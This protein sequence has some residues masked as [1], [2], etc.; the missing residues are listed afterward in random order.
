M[1]SATIGGTVAGAGNTIAFNNGPGVRIRNGATGILVEGNAIHS[2]AGLGID[3]M[4]GTENGFAVTANDALDA[5]GGA[6]RLQNYPLLYGANVVG[7]NLTVYGEINSTASRL[8]RIEFFASPAADASGYGEGA[9]YLGFMNVTT[10]AAG[11][12]Q[13]STTLVGAAVAAGEVITATATDTTT[14]DTS[15][16]SAS[17]VANNRTLSGTVYN[18]LN[19]NANVADDGGAV[20]ANATVR[21]YM[22]DGDGVMDAGDVSLGATTTNGAGLYSFSNLG[23]ATYWV[24]VDSKTL[25]APAYNGVF[26]INDVWADQTYGDDSTTGALDL[27]ARYGGR[28]AAVSDN[29]AALTTAEHV[30]R[31]TIAGAN[32]TGVDSGFSFSAIVNTRGDTTDDDAANARLQQGSLRQF[33]LNSNAIAGVQTSNFSIGGGGAQTITLTASLANLTDAAVLNATTQEGFAGSPLIE[34]RGGGVAVN[35]F[36]V[37]T[38][39][40]GSTIRGFVIS[41]FTADA[42]ELIGDNNLVGGNWIGTDATGNAAAALR[43]AEAGVRIRAGADNNTVG[44][45]TAADRNVLSGNG[46]GGDPSDN[47]LTLLGGNNTIQGNYI[48]VGADGTTVIGNTDEGMDVGTGATNNLIGGLVAGAGNIIAGSVGNLGIAVQNTA[49]GT[50]I[51]GNTIYGNDG[52]IRIQNTSTGTT[53]SRNSIYGNA[54]LGINLAGGVE[55]NDVTANDVGD[56]DTGPNGLQN[57]PVLASAVTNGATQITIIGSLNSTASRTFRIEFFS[58]PAADA[59]SGHGEG[60]TYLGFVDVTT[61]GSGNASFNTTLAANVPVGASITATA[62]DLT[63]NETSEFAL[64][65]AAS[66][67]RSVSGTVYDDRNGD[68][69]VSGAEGVFANATVRLYADDGDGVIDAGD[70]FL[71]SQATDALGAYAFSG[72][73][74][75][76]YWVTVDSKTLTAPAYNGAFTINDVWAEQTYAAAGGA[77]NAAGTTFTGAAGALYGGR[78]AATTDDASALATA[79]HVVRAVVAGANVTGIDA[80]FSFS[81]VVNTRGD[82]LDADGGGTARLHQGSLRQFILN[83]NAIAGVQTSNFSIGGGGAQSIA[84]TAALATITDA[85]VLDATT[86]EGFAGT[87]LIELRGNLAGAGVN[88]FLISSAG[89]STVR[90]FAIDRFTDRGIRISAGSGH[91]IAGNLIGTDAADSAGIGNLKGISVNGATSVTIGGAAAADRNVISGNVEEGIVLNNADGSIVRGNRIGTNAAGTA[92]VGNGWEGIQLSNGASGLIV[93]DNLISGNGR[94]GIRADNA[95][96]SGTIIGNTIG[97]NLAGTVAIANGAG[98][99]EGG[100]Y[101]TGGAGGFIIGG[102]TAAERNVISGNTGAGITL[103]ASNGNTISGNYVGTNATGTAARANSVDGI[104]LFSAAGNTIGGAPGGATNVLSGNGRYGV[105]LDASSGNFIRGNNI[106][107]NAAGTGGVGNTGSGVVLRNASFSNTIGGVGFGNVIGANQNGISVEGAGTTGN[108]IRANWIG[109]DATGTLN[110]GNAEEGVEMYS[111]ASGN[112]IGGTAAGAGNTIANNGFGGSNWD[113]IWIDTT[114]TATTIEG[115]AIYGNA[116]LGIDIDANG[117]TAND[118]GDA[119]AGGNNRQNFP[120]LHER[121]RLRRQRHDLRQPEQHRE[122]HVPHRVLRQRRSGSRGRRER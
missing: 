15:E 3:L 31:V 27:A 58:N 72:L 85:V 105:F 103:S 113:G 48:G 97:L 51:V 77:N 78:A 20:F 36:N 25:A 14:N 11:Y 79:E 21:L 6:N 56:A 70:I 75:A 104:A 76:T 39:G 45:T 52:G 81:A 115:N 95:G 118:A 49:T 116:G 57:F 18:D 55:T 69:A 19:G 13:Y 107:V 10:N 112:T 44:G 35:A 63:A 47:G 28:N 43:N 98:N 110:L 26:T 91:L 111:S 62:T 5:D 65:I 80:G 66:A 102:T 30:A 71:A 119:D 33:V 22:D 106:G 60:Q 12:F 88:G 99:S 73:G 120:V 114:V 86:Q 53:V 16:F 7:A 67:G 2:N 54:R 109:T 37:Q 90:G 32:A 4:G 23:N 122:P 8:F 9:R 29:A 68:A 101:L 93:Q 1:S 96:T 94:A 87:P 59:P 100:I 42:I 38:A 64:N 92:G 121:D 40:S 74:N 108:V 89:A 24:T 34:L 82:T 41:G 50:S 117:V 61:D 84:P 46:I 83:S 17:V